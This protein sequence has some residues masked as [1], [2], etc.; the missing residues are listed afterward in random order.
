MFTRT[1]KKYTVSEFESRRVFGNYDFHNSE[2][3][4]IC[5]VH[6]K[7]NTQRRPRLPADEQPNY[8]DPDENLFF[9]AI[10]PNHTN[11]CGWT[12]GSFRN[13]APVF[14]GSGLLLNP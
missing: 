10:D 6:K 2:R 14:E 9:V 8:R 7:A 13:S 5:N 1:A 12:A 11:L 4:R 3:K